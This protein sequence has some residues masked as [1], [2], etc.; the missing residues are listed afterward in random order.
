MCLV[1]HVWVLLWGL[2]FFRYLSSDVPVLLSLRCLVMKWS[3]ILVYTTEG[4]MPIPFPPMVPEEVSRLKGVVKVIFV[5]F[6]PSVQGGAAALANN[7]LKIRGLETVGKPFI[8]SNTQSLIWT[9]S[10]QSVWHIINNLT[11]QVINFQWEGKQ[12]S[13]SFEVIDPEGHSRLRVLVVR[14]QFSKG[15]ISAPKSRLRGAAMLAA[16]GPNHHFL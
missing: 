5:P 1:V 4:A 13:Y 14:C 9:I 3:E 6:G 10:A 15:Y 12:I 7:L 8:V 11:S 2:I 16:S